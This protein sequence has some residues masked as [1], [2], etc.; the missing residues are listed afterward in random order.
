MLF[1]GNNRQAKL[2]ALDRSQA[3][4]E[5]ELDGTIITA[6]ENFLKTLGYGLDEI[7]GK[8]HSLFVD[9]ATRESAE[10]RRF[11]ASLGRGEHQSAEYRRIG[12]AA[13]RSG[14]RPPTTRS[15]AATASRAGS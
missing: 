11:W 12:R 10:Y 6:N 13:G 14:S 8:H 3:V 7:K 5:F 9:P 1:G 2:A 15:S 4:I